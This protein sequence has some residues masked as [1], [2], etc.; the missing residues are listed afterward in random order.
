MTS[1]R[2]LFFIM[3]PALVIDAA[4]GWLIRNVTTSVSLSQVYRVTMLGLMLLWLA[5]YRRNGFV[6]LIGSFTLLEMGTLYHSFFYRENSWLMYDI[7]FQVRMILHFVYFLFFWTFIQQTMRTSS[8]PVLYRNLQRLFVFSYAVVA[9]NII[10]G[11]L[12]IGYSTVSKFAGGDKEG[13]G[14]L[15]FFKA[16]NDV[17]STF[18]LITGIVMYWIWN[19]RKR[20]RGYI[21]FGVF[22][23]LMAVLLQT[24]TIIIGMLILFGGIPLVS[25]GLILSQWRI[26]KRP[27]II[28]TL[29][30]VA[31]VSVS[32]WLL[33]SN[34]GIV[35]KFVFFYEKSGLTFALL[36][37]RSYFLNLAVNVINKSYG[38]LDILFGHGWS[39]YLEEMGSLYGGK[40]KLVEIDYVDIFMING[41]SGLILQLSI[42]TFY[43]L[44]AYK[45]ARI[46]SLGRVVLFIDLMLLGIA[47]TAGHVLYS[48]LNSM[49]VGILNTLPFIERAIRPPSTEKPVPEVEHAAIHT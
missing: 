21:I 40:D 15:G 49:F 16:G 39:Y 2:L 46:S 3:F 24:K 10:L 19:G 30:V 35:R 20:S 4:N 1:A 33:V 36:T 14:G 5:K 7:H 17:S 42:W 45:R 29:A 9:V 41:L 8:Q 28:I 34:A 27:L 22:S 18:L 37:G 48:T 38:F 43:L 31:V 25:S 23:L 32:I 44:S 26:K 11:T 47:G 13:F 12:G 6:M